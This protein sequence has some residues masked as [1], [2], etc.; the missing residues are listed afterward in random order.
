M[1]K[2]RYTDE[3]EAAI[4]QQYLTR[5]PD[6][7]WMG[8]NDLAKAWGVYP[9][10]IYNALRRQGVQTRD[11]VESHA[12]GKR[13]KPITV[14]PEGTAPLCLC[15][16]GQTVGWNQNKRRWLM[17]V[18]GHYKPASRLY[19]DPDWLY[20]NYV[21]QRRSTRDIARQ[22]GVKESTV[23]MHMIR[24]GI[25]RRDASEAHRGLQTGSN[26]PAWKGGTT[27]E[28]Q[29]LYKKGEWKQ[30][31]R[32]VLAR[33]NYTCKCCGTY[34]ATNVPK[35]VTHHVK[36]FSTHP[37]LRF[38]PDN[39]VTLCEKCHRWVHSKANQDRLFLG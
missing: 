23:R 3:Q 1:P 36:P 19:K 27:P 22:Y 28:R 25:P 16:C 30:L 5:L 20:D 6:G 2:R 39:L 38:D 33:D 37:E 9:Q 34:R 7:T 11:A 18:K 12:H 13:C 26:N 29:R 35:L 15:G 4:A 8:A 31:V 32:D 14:H 24:F 17:H 21:N 10:I